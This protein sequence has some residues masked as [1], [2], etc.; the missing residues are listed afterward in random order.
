MTSIM[1]AR[2][3]AC[4]QGLGRTSAKNT[5]MRWT[6]PWRTSRLAGL[7][8]RWGRAGAHQRRVVRAVGQAGVPAAA[9]DPQPVV[10]DPVVDLDLGLAELLSAVEELKGD[11][12]LALGDDLDD[13]ERLG[14]ADPGPVEQPQGVVLLL[15]QPP[16]GVERLLVLQP[17]VEQ[18]P[19]Q[20]V[21]AVGAEGDAGSE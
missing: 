11:Q 15:D 14:A 17:A 1:L 10:D 3:T 5:S 21:P 9:D 20:L 2:S 6:R 7:M 16:D 19:A 13:P 18:G 4:R 8:S 12:V